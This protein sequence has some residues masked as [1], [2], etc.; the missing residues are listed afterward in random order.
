MPSTFGP[1]VEQVGEGVAGQVSRLLMAGGAGDPSS[2]LDRMADL[3]EDQHHLVYASFVRRTATGCGVVRLGDETATYLGDVLATGAEEHTRVALVVRAL[4]DV[5]SAG[6]A[7]LEV[8]P[9]V[10]GSDDELRPLGLADQWD[11]AR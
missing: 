11:D 1:H 7:W 2:L 3:A 4:H 10:M 5:A 8:P 9:E 6:V